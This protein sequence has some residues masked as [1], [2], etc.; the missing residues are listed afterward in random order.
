MR[1]ALGC[2]GLGGGA[3][4]TVRD[5]VRL[6]QG[7]IDLGVMVFDTADVYGG[8]ASERVLGRAVKARRS[9]VTIATKGGFVFRDRSPLEQWGRRR[10]KWVRDVVPRPSGG[11]TRAAVGSG[12][13]A[14]Q[15][16]SAR[17]LRDAVH[18]SLRRL[19]T[20][21]IDVYQLHGPLAMIPGVIEQLWDLVATGDV[22][23]FGVGADTEEI[24]DLWI[25]HPGI[26]VIQV[27]FGV[28]DT[29]A[30]ATT[31]VSA[32]GSGVELWARGVLGGGLL[33][34]VGN[35]APA[36]NGHPKAARVRDL[37]QLAAAAGIDPFQL[38]FGFVR[39]H[40]PDVTTA[41]VGTTSLAH[42]Q[43]NLELCAAAPLD[44]ELVDAVIA[45]ADRDQNDS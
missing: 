41:L 1:L 7:A 8:G 30:A 11:P 17:H 5:D 15:D 9:E 21:W 33:G 38:A 36:I 13:Y 18:A 16:F 24:A 35:G 22:V 19:G 14:V 43:R 26:G 37:Q 28:L 6:V 44:S 25:D 31:L 20:G 45:L 4:R 32:R 2:V 29:A 10:A 42:L 40:E 27:P 39:A 12:A 23:R 34:A 3:R